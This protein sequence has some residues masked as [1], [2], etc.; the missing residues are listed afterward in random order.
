[1]QNCTFWWIRELPPPP[2]IEPSI[3][4]STF[5][6]EGV[7]FVDVLILIC[8]WCLS[9][10]KVDPAIV[11]LSWWQAPGWLIKGVDFG[12][13]GARGRLTSS[14]R[15]QFR[16]RSCMILSG[17]AWQWVADAV[18]KICKRRTLNASPPLY[19]SSAIQPES[20]TLLHI[21]AAVDGNEVAPPNS[22]AKGRIWGY[23]AAWANSDVFRE[24]FN[25][26]RRYCRRSTSS[27]D[28]FFL[29]WNSRYPFELSVNKR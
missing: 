20:R 24:R 26:R 21:Y 7:N 5:R 25:C 14:S 6:I 22:T 8:R 27:G 28:D 15:L 10:I 2:H 29:S 16:T 18:F 3:S 23:K 13:W 1:M 11:Y 9:R 17:A 19:N 12:A 4:R